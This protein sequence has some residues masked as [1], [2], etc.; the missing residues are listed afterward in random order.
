MHD[1]GTQV[2]LRGWPEG[3]GAGAGWRG[4]RRDNCN[5]INN[6][7]IGKQKKKQN[8]AVAS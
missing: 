3:R 5:S 7:N 4:Q 1:P 6:K 2:W 8:V